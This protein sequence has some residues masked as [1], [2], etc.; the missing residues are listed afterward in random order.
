MQKTRSI[1]TLSKLNRGSAPFLKSEPP[2][3]LLLLMMIIL[4]STSNL[5]IKL[6]G[7]PSSAQ[8]APKWVALP[9]TCL[10]FYEM[11]TPIKFFLIC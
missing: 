1:L 6:H 10:P 2:A 5:S 4:H 11:T 3:I 8:N 7:M 9:R